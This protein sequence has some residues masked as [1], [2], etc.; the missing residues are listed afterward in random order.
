MTA[1]IPA[2]RPGEPD[3][4]ARLA[5]VLLSDDLS[6]YVSGANLTVDGA[7]SLTSWLTTR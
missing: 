3:D 1:H 2:G 4:V 5:I 6:D 7:L